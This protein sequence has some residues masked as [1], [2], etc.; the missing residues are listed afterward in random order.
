MAATMAGAATAST[1][2]TAT[3]RPETIF[4]VKS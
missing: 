3:T 1:A 4:V 2:S